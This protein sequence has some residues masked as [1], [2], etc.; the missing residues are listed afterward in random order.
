MDFFPTI[1]FGRVRGLFMA[2][3]FEYP[4]DVATL[5]AQICCHD[6]Q[7]PQG[8]PTSPIVSNYICRKLDSQLS[9]L[10]SSE[11]CYFTRYAD[12]IAISTDRTVFPSRVALITSGQSLAGPSLAGLIE[13]NGFEINPAKTRL[14]RRTQR[15]RIT[16]LVVNEKVNVSRHYVRDL[17]NL[18]FAWRTHGEDV[19]VELWRTRDPLVNWPPGKQHPNF[20]L[21]MRGR[22]QYVG[23]I[24]G[25]T[26]SVYVGLAESLRSVDASFKPKAIAQAKA[27]T[28]VGLLTEGE[29]DQLHLLAAQRYFHDQNEFTEF[30]LVSDPSSPNAGDQELLKACEGLALSRQTHPRLCVFDR[31]RK[32]TLKKAVGTGD[33]KN[34]GNGV[35]SVALL[36]PNEPWLCIEML[37]DDKTRS[38][39]DEQGRRM[40]LSKEFDPRTGHHPSRRYTITH[41]KSSKLIPDDVYEIETG[42]SVGLS[43]MA[44]A[45][46]VYGQNGAFAAVSFEGFRETFEVI[47]E[48][49]AS[50]QHMLVEQL[51]SPTGGAPDDHGRGAKDR[52]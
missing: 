22:V 27:E 29:S 5:L 25:W 28:R 52:R 38:M 24:K 20:K 36:G 40:F 7:L 32:D 43:K 30:H 45:K 12:D 15:Q 9:R 6:N 44:F 4:A 13:S 18:L 50:V 35:A 41:P 51:A 48:A 34:W 42:D 3:P 8:A 26:S 37:H 23:S 1:N 16:G 31:D 17:R 47:R 19:A 39:K 2:Y 21:V 49:V 33:W 11:R 10:A 46:A 14:M